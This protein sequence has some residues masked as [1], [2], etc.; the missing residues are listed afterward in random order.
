MSEQSY[1][2]PYFELKYYE[3][4]NQVDKASELL[5]NLIIIDGLFFSASDTNKFSLGYQCN[6]DRTDT[7]KQY[8]SQLGNGRDYKRASA[9]FHMD[10]YVA[11]LLRFFCSF[12]ISIYISNSIQK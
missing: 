5:S 11:F 7:T 10:I 1:F 12:K 2:F 4:S 6:L 3:Y 9:T 8:L